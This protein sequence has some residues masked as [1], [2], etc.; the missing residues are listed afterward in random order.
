MIYNEG[1]IIT[2]ADPE[3]NVWF[4]RFGNNANKSSNAM[5]LSR[6][7]AQNWYNRLMLM[8]VSR[9]EWTGLP[10]GITS[11]WI[12][13][14]LYQRGSMAFFHNQNLGYLCLGYATNGKVNIYGQPNKIIA[15]GKTSDKFRLNGDDYVIIKDN[16]LA[17]PLIE[18]TRL[19]AYRLTIVERTLDVN[20]IAQRFPYIVKGSPQEMLSLKN[21]MQQLDDFETYI[22]VDD[23]MDMQERMAVLPTVAP[24]VGDKIMLYKHEIIDEY[25]TEL[26]LSNANTDKKER[27]IVDE[28]NAN[29]EEVKLSISM[30]LKSRR[31]A[32]EQINE[33]YKLNIGVNEIDMSDIDFGFDLEE[34]EEGEEYDEQN[35]D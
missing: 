2:N 11:D 25:L 31:D 20:V 14:E 16:P 4:G 5:H 35:N 6:T 15:S 28:V 8:A 18:T 27:L 21:M 17:Y 24:Y 30:A 29:N 26:G 33:K 19:Y 1:K 7:T 9:F 10:D 13:T 12:E 34:Q 22:M 3:L 23:S 32:C